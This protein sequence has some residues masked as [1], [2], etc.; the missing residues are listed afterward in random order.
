MV[1]GRFAS[2]VSQESTYTLVV[3]LLL[4]VIWDTKLAVFPSGIKDV[5]FL[6]LELRST[7]LISDRLG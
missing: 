2:K 5:D 4:L 3:W 1:F 6:S 7:G